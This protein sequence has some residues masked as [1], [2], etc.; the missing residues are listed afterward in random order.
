MRHVAIADGRLVGDLVSVHTDGIDAAAISD[1]HGPIG[2][3]LDDGV[4]AGDARV[5]EDEVVGVAATDGDHRF[6]DLEDAAF[7]FRR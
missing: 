1:D 2:K 6:R 3:L 4:K 5:V 7:S